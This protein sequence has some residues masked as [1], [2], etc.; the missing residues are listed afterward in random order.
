M[1][2]NITHIETHGSELHGQIEHATTTVSYLHER[3]TLIECS[4]NTSW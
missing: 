2:I 4:Q 1:V 3:L